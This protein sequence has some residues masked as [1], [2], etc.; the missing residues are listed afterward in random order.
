MNKGIISE[1]SI[2]VL[3]VEDNIVNQ[4]VAINMLKIQGYDVD[5]ANNGQQAIEAL[6]KEKYSMVVMDCE[7]PVMNGYEAT[8]EWRKLEQENNRQPVPIIALTAHAISGEREK[9][10]ACG[11]TDF[12]S[13]PFEFDNL[14]DT[15][16]KWLDTN[17][18]QQSHKVIFDE[19]NL[20]AKADAIHSEPEL[21]LQ[22]QKEILNQEKLDQL[23]Y[24]QGK[25]NTVLVKKVVRLFLEQ[26][27]KMISEM[28]RALQQG[29]TED[30]FAIA[31][32]LKSSS[33]TVGATGLMELCKKIEGCR[34]S[35]AIDH[36]LID[37]ARQ[38]SAEVELALRQ[39]LEKVA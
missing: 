1:R 21:P 34:S 7:M 38:T 35:D 23:R 2:K 24:W 14:R 11:M 3:L 12:I 27:P 9:C 16:S 28:E 26:M 13:K 4:E 20:T 5:V 30:V 10:L 32:T 8:R 22:A 33:A 25:P 19:K 31:H 15:L 36:A 17:S 29:D 18:S 6:K 37:Q 39:E